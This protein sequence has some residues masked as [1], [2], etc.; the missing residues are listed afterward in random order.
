M[1][2]KRKEYIMSK[3]EYDVFED[4]KGIKKQIKGWE[5]DTDK[6]INELWKA[7]EK[8]KEDQDRDSIHECIEGLEAL[9]HDM[10]SINM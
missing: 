4:I 1:V 3:K 2:L 5:H 8:L 9:S 10:M 6:L 7:R